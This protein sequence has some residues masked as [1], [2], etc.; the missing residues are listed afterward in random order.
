MLKQSRISKPLII[1]FRQFKRQ[2]SLKMG[3][4]GEKVL[5]VVFIGL[6]AVRRLAVPAPSEGFI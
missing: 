2:D 1:I 5:T 3:K 4:L 6:I